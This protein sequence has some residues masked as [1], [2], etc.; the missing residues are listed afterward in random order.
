MIEASRTNKLK[1]LSVG[2]HYFGRGKLY[3]EIRSHKI[4]MQSRL[5]L[6][7]TKDGVVW[8]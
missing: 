5:S 4:V 6:P 7:I 3:R 2:G 8:T 1:L